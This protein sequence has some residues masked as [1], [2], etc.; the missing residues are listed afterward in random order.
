MAKKSKIRRR[1]KIRT[2]KTKTGRTK[3]YVLRLYITG[4]TSLSSASVRNLLRVC[5]SHLQ[6]RYDIQVIDICQQPEL[7]R[8]AQIIATP[9][10]VR[11]H[12]VPI[13][14]LIGNLSDQAQ[15]LA[16]LGIRDEKRPN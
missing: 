13:R 3:A 8:E 5:Q 7:A 10:L 16:E 12:P 15:L 14:K 6:G 9:T 2:A 4:Q 11:T 1:T